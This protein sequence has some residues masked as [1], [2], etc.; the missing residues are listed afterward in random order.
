MITYVTMAVVP[1]SAFF[2]DYLIKNFSDIE[3]YGSS[4]KIDLDSLLDQLPGVEANDIKVFIEDTVNIISGKAE[5]IE[6]I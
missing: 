5:A 4:V 2:K 3:E 6:F 1:A